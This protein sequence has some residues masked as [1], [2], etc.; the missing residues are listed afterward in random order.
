MYALRARFSKL[1]AVLAGAALVTAVVVSPV[2]SAQPAVPGALKLAQQSGMKVIKTFA[3]TKTLTGYVVQQG[4]QNSVLYG[5]ADGF[6]IAGALLGPDGTNLTS[7]HA[8][9]YAAPV[10]DISA[11]DLAKLTHIQVGKGKSP[12]YVFFDT[13]CSFCRVLQKALAP[14]EKAGLTVRWVPVAVLSPESLTGGA[15]VLASNDPA[16]LVETLSKAGKP[17]GQPGNR[18]V[19]PEFLKKVEQN[20]LTMSEM[21]ISGTPAIVYGS[22]KKF[23]VKRGMPRLSELPAITGLPKQT[24]SDPELSRFE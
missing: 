6:L 5:T 20:S 3:A 12:I 24:I 2:A 17:A 21:G 10:A 23:S 1:N 18:E 8:E 15:Q 11:A 22:G 16:K 19:S 14:Y 9:K 13:Q 7:L 4:G